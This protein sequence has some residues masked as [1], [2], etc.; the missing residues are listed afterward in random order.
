MGPWVISILVAWHSFSAGGASPQARLESDLSLTAQESATPLASVD[1][2][3]IYPMMCLNPVGPDGMPIRHCGGVSFFLVID[4]RNCRY[5]YFLPV[6][7]H[8]LIG[9]PRSYW[10]GH[11]RWFADLDGPID[12]D[13][14]GDWDVDDIQTVLWS[15]AGAELP[16]PRLGDVCPVICSDGTIDVQDLMATIWGFE[17]HFECGW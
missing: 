13:R 16:G 10:A 8:P 15:I 17:G 3:I 6:P 14:D 7:A 2:P 9:H 12:A 5:P 4:H 11:E 1:D